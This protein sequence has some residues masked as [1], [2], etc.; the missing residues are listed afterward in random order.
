MI[1]L[2]MLACDGKFFTVVL[3]F[4]MKIGSC[5]HVVDVV[6]LIGAPQWR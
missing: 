3:A 5:T 6:I 1:K 4:I 2:Q